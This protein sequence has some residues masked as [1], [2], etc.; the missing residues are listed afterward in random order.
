VSARSLKTLFSK[1]FL[2]GLGFLGLRQQ[3]QNEERDSAALPP[4][5]QPPSVQITIRRH[6]LLGLIAVLFLIVGVGGWAALSSIAGAIIAT[7]KLAVNSYVKPVQ[8]PTG[9]IVGEIHVKNGDHVTSGAVLVRLDDTQARVNLAIVSQR[10]DELR[11]RAARLETERDGLETITFSAD[12]MARADTAEVAKLLKG[13]QRLFEARR[14]SRE[15]QKAQLHERIAQLHQEIDGIASQI[16]GKIREI[17]L[18]ERELE[19]VRKLWQQGLVPLTRLH[20]LERDAARLTGERG[21]LIATSAQTK[22]RITETEL[23]I[24]QIDEDLQSEVA[25]ETRDIQAQISEYAERQVAAQEELRR[26]DIRSPQDGV[27]HELTVHA[28]GAIIA[29]GAPIM[30]IVP[31]A[32]D[33]IIEAQISPQDI[34]QIHLDQPAL[35]RFSAFNQRTT[36][37]I[38]GSI[39]RIAADLTTSSEKEASYYLVRIAVPESEIALLGDVKLIPGMPIEAFIQ[40]GERSALSYF[41]K[42]LSDQVARAFRE[43]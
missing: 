40:T 31:V 18:I 35:L 19:G 32:D 4:T 27:V 17:R 43:E 30:M 25:N 23:Q 22:G 12:L 1:A 11:T 28:P 8:H 36:P 3:A 9:G 21:S 5:G 14:T 38:K 42:P 29:Q 7:G 39:S 26:I 2:T 16:D 20:S 34:D 37:E 10:L 15:G 33:L 6:L 13:E 24:L 41:L